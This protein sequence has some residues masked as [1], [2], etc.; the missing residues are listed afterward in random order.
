MREAEISALESFIRMSQFGNT[1]YHV[2]GA[3]LDWKCNVRCQT[4]EEDDKYDRVVDPAG[5]WVSKRARSC[6]DELQFQPCHLTVTRGTPFTDRYYLATGRQCR[7]SLYFHH[8]RTSAS[9][10]H[11]AHDG[12]DGGGMDSFRRP[13]YDASNR[14]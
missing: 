7:F 4:P 9:S 8:E 11:A 3:K 2:H 10:A 1:K 14:R 5:K 6:K 12:C 13:A